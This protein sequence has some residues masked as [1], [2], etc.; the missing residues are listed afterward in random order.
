[1]LK[2]F[3]SD[4]ITPRIVKTKIIIE[5]SIFIPDG[6]ED[7]TIILVNKDGLYLH[8]KVSSIP[9]Q[10]RNAHGV[11][12]SFNDGSSVR[13][14]LTNSNV[15]SFVVLMESKILSEGYVYIIPIE[16]I[17]IGN[18]CNT[19]K[20]LFDF[21]DFIC[22]GIGTIDLTLK[23]QISLFISDDSTIGL[24]TNNFK[25]IKSPRKISCKAFD[26]VTLTI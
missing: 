1:M 11:K 23:D 8:F 22:S 17:K 25:N 21:K 14:A 13:M 4:E 19:L 10:G 12:T 9:V 2:R 7:D 16:K 6:S 5:N 3:N 18:R 15:N 24:K 26:I 20:K